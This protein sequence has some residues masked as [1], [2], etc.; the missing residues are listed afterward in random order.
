MV[1][2]LGVTAGPRRRCSPRPGP[3][4]GAHPRRPGELPEPAG[5]G[6]RM[7]GIGE[8]CRRQA[9]ETPQKLGAGRRQAVEDPETQAAPRTDDPRV[10]GVKLGRRVVPDDTVAV[11]AGD[12]RQTARPSASVP[13]RGCGR[14]A[15]TGGLFPGRR[16]AASGHAAGGVPRSRPAS[17]SSVG[18]H[19]AARPRARP[20]SG[21]TC[22]ARASGRDPTLRSHRDQPAGPCQGARPSVSPVHGTPTGSCELAVPD[23]NASAPLRAPTSDAVAWRCASI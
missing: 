16:S 13:R 20:G 2:G 10:E 21:E 5:H 12:Q 9:T 19:A 23:H 7:G 4:G 22:V 3:C 8:R 15:R 17:G 14:H 1:S 11:T 18:W 6:Q